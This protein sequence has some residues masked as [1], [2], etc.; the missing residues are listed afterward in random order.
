MQKTRN[1]I[2]ELMNKSGGIKGIHVLRSIMEFSS[3]LYILN[4]Y[5]YKVNA[6]DPL[7]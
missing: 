6:L 2:L 7:N 1:S 3:L 4:N 5:F